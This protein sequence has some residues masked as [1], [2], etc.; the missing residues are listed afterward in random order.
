MLKIPEWLEVYL[1]NGAKFFVLFG[2][3]WKIGFAHP[4]SVL[5][6]IFLPILCAALLLT[7][8][9]SYEV[10]VHGPIVF[11]PFSTNLSQVR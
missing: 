1:V 3:D 11:Q 10:Q 7:Q 9:L 8:R 4:Q 2:K 5:T 6:N